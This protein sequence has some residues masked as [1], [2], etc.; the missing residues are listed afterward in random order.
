MLQGLGLGYVL[1]HACKN[2][3][4]LYWVE[5]KDGQECLHHG[6]SRW[7]INNGKDNKIPHKVLR[8]FP[9]K[10]RHQRLFISSKTSVD[11]RWHKEKHHDEENVLRHPV[12]S[13]AW[14]EFDTNHLLFA[15]EYRNIKLSL[16]T[17]G[18]HP[19]SNMSTS[20]SMWP[21]ILALYNL[22]PWKCFKDP[23]MMMSLLIPSPQALRKDIDIYLRPLIDGLKELWSDGVETFDAST[24]KCFKMH[25]VVLWTINDLPAYATQAKQV[26]YMEDP[27]LGEN[28][29]IALKFQDKHLYDVP[30]KET[31]ETE[32][33]ELHIKNDEVYQDMSLES[34]SIVCDTVDMLSQLH[35][36][37]VDFVILDANVIELEAQKE[38][39]VHYNEE[40]SDQENETMIE[41]ISDHDENED[42]NGTND[43]EADTTSD[44]DDIGL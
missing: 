25:D 21:D 33:D 24:E 23:F 10:P 5:Y 31:L 38:Q 11:M 28:F 17:D 30:E 44:G 26:F 29:Q 3:Y 41:Y 32:S 7:K 39:E 36:D 42:N 15:Y 9:L 27:K 13:E 35:R 18:F 6:T 22:P 19:F 14:K 1:I 43:N 2:D 12:D 34:N 16:A 8:Y 37:D 40:N 4:M 20:Y